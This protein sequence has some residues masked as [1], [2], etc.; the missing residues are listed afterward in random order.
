MR[1]RV[2]TFRVRLLALASPDTFVLRCKRFYRLSRSSASRGRSLESPGWSLQTDL[3]IHST[4]CRS[5]ARVNSG[6]RQRHSSLRQQSFLA[7]VLR[8][9]SFSV[10]ATASVQPRAAALRLC[11]GLS[12]Q[13]LAFQHRICWFSPRIIAGCCLTIRSSRDRFAASADSGN[14]LL[15]Q[16]RKAVRLNSGVRPLVACCATC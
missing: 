15:C 14:M 2:K 11:P 6:V 4:R 8:Y 3:T 12:P 7:Q 13:A 10:N 5:A 9:S 16:G 1:G